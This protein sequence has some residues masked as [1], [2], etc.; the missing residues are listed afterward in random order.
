M[1]AFFHKRTYNYCALCF[2]K[3]AVEGS[4]HCPACGQ[5][6]TAI[7]LFDKV[8]RDSSFSQREKT[9]LRFCAVII[10]AVILLEIVVCFVV[11]A[12]IPKHIENLEYLAGEKVIKVTASN[13]SV[14]EKLGTPP[15]YS[16]YEFYMDA[17]D[18]AGLDALWRN[19]GL[20]AE[21]ISYWESV[22]LQSYIF[23]SGKDG[24]KHELNKNSMR[25]DAKA[26]LEV[27]RSISPFVQPLLW[28]VIILQAAMMI[29]CILVVLKKEWAFQSMIICMVVC[30][31][32][33]F[34]H[35]NLICAFAGVYVASQISRIILKAESDSPHNKEGKL[36][37]AR[38][39]VLNRNEWE[40][41]SCGYVNSDSV[42][43]CKSCGKYK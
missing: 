32:I 15:S 29:P 3:L 42:L 27:M 4:N 18:S 28:I 10:I 13:N 19:S 25:E 41:K 30:A 37:R 12:I 7:G 21:Q 8:E 40:C 33:A 22:Y 26:E 17:N 43:E 9:E 6:T 35:G 34:M 31:E 1:A 38:R 20:T 39:L 23:S 2:H 5:K 14:A 16:D 24:E 11:M 36:K